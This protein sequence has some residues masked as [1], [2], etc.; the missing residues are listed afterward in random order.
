MKLKKV[1]ILATV[2]ILGLTAQA[3]NQPERPKLVV[4]LMVDQM[5]WDYLYRFAD[6]Y[7]KGG[8]K[9]LLNDGFTCQNTYI[10]YIPTY[11]AI[12]HSSVYTGSVPSI[13][14]I[15]GN[16]WIMEQ[17]G[18]SMYCTQD[19]SVTGVGTTEKE[20]K[21]SPRNLLTS[22]VT[23][24]LRLATN[25]K[26]KVIGIALKDRGGILPAGHF[27][28]AAYWFESKSGNWISSNFY[29]D[30]LPKWVQDFNSRKLA[31]KYLKQDWNTLYD[32]STYTSSIADDNVYEGKWA[33]EDKPTFPHLTSKLMKDEGYELI[34]TTPYGN[35]LTLDLAKAAIENEKM[36]NNPTKN[37]DFLCV[38]L[39]STD[40]VGHRYSLSA[41]EIEDTYL[42]LDQQLEEFF[43]YLD[44]TVGQGNYTLFLT[45]DH[46]ASYNSR[47]FMD[48][49]GNGG[50]FF[51]RQVMKDLDAALNAKFGV[52][53]LVKSLMNYQV[54]L[55]YPLIEKSN[56]D[57][58]KVKEEII[59][60]LKKE[61]GIAYVVDVEK[62]DNMAI[63]Q[64]IRERIINGYNM[65]RSGVIQIV[66]EP[67]WYDGSPRS[68]GTTHGTWTPY[69]S[70][71][72]LIFMGWGI[73]PG[74]S[75][76][77][78]NMTDIAPTI[79][80]LL[81]ITEPNGN[82]GKPILEVLGQ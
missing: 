34:K 73:K 7:G 4:G 6:R 48:M 43:N 19:T 41:I 50:Y 70:H 36:G 58:D 59:K 33:G 1:L 57:V 29:M 68:T 45:A 9:R 37:T 67:Q 22:T 77:V 44:K 18:E 3:Q 17:T 8:F 42:R 20:G 66:L 16:D 51:S 53:K 49:K 30:Q 15:A 80:S 24:Q 31:D 25:F 26:S 54:H 64:P 72:P 82:I 27:A 2:G 74:A 40:Y 52:T 5:R 11:T 55:N 10:N 21:Q 69:D 35:Q 81:H 60:V 79:S 71:I 12:G 63:P 14:G 78:V 32:I 13:H 28:N 46:G 75:N 39:S 47:Y 23:D 38:S 56:L 62:G 65:K 76:R 61:E